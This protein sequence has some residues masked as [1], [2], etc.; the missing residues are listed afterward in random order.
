MHAWFH[1]AK[2]HYFFDM[3]IFRCASAQKCIMKLHYSLNNTGWVVNKLDW[4]LNVIRPFFHAYIFSG[5]IPSL[6]RESNMWGII[7]CS[8]SVTL[9]YWM[10]YRGLFCLV[11]LQVR[12]IR[13]ATHQFCRNIDGWYICTKHFL[14]IYHYG[15]QWQNVIHS[16]I[17]PINATYIYISF[18]GITR[19]VPHN[20]P[21]CHILYAMRDY[22]HFAQ[23]EMSE[24]LME[25]NNFF[26]WCAIFPWQQYLDNKVILS[27]YCCMC[28]CH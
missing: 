4:T 6:A 7:L 3:A 2:M 15:A 19:K 1:V 13:K 14:T 28:N 12:G 23:G 18:N 22:C 24:F 5:K 10:E 25:Q 8:K 16:P 21:V 9:P 26:R 20:I 27:L 11:K 17:S